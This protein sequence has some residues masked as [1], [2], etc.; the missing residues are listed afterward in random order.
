M[1]RILNIIA[2]IAIL[3]TGFCFSQTVEEIDQIIFSPSALSRDYK[4]DFPGT[5]EERS[6]TMKDGIVLNGV[7][8]RAK[9]SKGLV[10]YLHGSSGALNGWGKTAPNYTRLGYDIFI[11]DYRGYGKSGGKLENEQQFYDDLQYAYDDLKADYPEN[12]TII[13]GYSI[14][15]GPAAQL[16]ARNHPS[17]LILLAPYYS[18][19]DFL[20][21]LVPGIDVNLIRY[22]FK[23]YEFVQHVKAPVIIFHGEEDKV[24]YPGSSEKLKGFFK[25]N[26]QLHSLKGV[27]HYG[28]GESPAFLAE[29]GNILK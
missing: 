1:F 18:M 9:A 7:L 22:K 15:T 3:S 2:A 5:F 8:F 13:L 26:D 19:E 20:P 23:T 10:F 4:F 25:A 17:K 11:L 12:K 27:D 24:V 28:I 6:I 14:G 16:A 21:R 29:L